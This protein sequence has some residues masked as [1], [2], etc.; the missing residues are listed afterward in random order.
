MARAAAGELQHTV[1]FR[2]AS[3]FVPSVLDALRA[4][5]VAL[6]YGEH[7][8]RPFQ[9]EEATASWRFVR[10]HDGSRGRGGNYSA[11][12]ILEWAQ[13]I[14]Q[15]RQRERVFAYFNNDWRGFAPDNALALRRRLA[16]L[17]AERGTRLR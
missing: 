2:H 6:A 8:E 16:R 17:S 5:D 1:E 3:W 11:T 9:S 4:H 7:P 15:W 13:R 14:D 10:F 12:E